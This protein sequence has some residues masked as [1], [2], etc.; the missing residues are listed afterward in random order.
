MPNLR[1]CSRRAVLLA[2]FALML[3]VA[4]CGDRIDP[5]GR[6]PGQRRP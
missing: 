6:Q 4:G 2:L 3:P 5:G 1:P